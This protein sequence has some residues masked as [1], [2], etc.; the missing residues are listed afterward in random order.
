MEVHRDQRSGAGGANGE[1]SRPLNDEFPL[2]E[3]CETLLASGKSASG[4]YLAQLFLS[5]IF[6]RWH[7]DNHGVGI[8][9]IVWRRKPL[10]DHFDKSI[11]VLCDPAIFKGTPLSNLRGFI[12][13][14]LFKLCGGYGRAGPLGWESCPDARLVRALLND[15]DTFGCKN[16]RDGLVRL[17]A[18]HLGSQRK[19]RP[20][21]IT[22]V[23]RQWDTSLLNKEL[24]APRM[25]I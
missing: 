7:L 17:I 11:P 23:R 14:D 22:A 1:D 20:R 3:I 5:H 18:D 8:R 2:P 16:M 13:D 10:T 15:L 21:V 19:V 9:G 24:R 25:V 6:Y 12:S 4:V